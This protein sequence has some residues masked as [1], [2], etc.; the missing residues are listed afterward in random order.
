[1]VAPLVLVPGPLMD[2]RIFLPQM[3]ALAGTCPVLLPVLRPS[4]AVE[5]IAQQVLDGVPGPFSVMGHGVGAMAVMEMLR[6]APER[7]TR[8]VLIATD[9]LTDAASLSAAREAQVVQARAGRLEEVLAEDPAVRAYRARPD[10]ADLAE[11]ILDMARARGAEG[12][13]AHIRALQRRPDQQRV[14]RQTRVPVL[15]LG[16][17]EDP[18]Q[19]ARR[20][21]FTA[22]LIR[23]GSLAL[24]EGAGH[25]VT[26]E[27]PD[28]VNAAL[29]AFLDQPLPEARISS[30]P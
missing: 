7:I 14:L 23:H 11:V 12:F 20:Q 26:L 19:P 21:E 1:M 27:A 10:C 9:P 16:G 25:L 5:D 2:S 15:C 13:A 6:R 4:G 24:I 3:L 29:A 30:R 8:A 17:V 28:A 22:G 18:V